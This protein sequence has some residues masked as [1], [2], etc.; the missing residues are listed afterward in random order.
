[1]C[2]KDMKSNT[3]TVEHRRNPNKKS[4][5]ASDANH[6]IA[7]SMV[8]VAIQNTNW[9]GKTPSV[10]S[11]YMVR[12]RYRQPFVRASILDISNASQT[13]TLVL[14]ENTDPITPG[15]SLVIYSEHANKFQVRECLG[16]GIICD[17]I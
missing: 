10:G 5:T 6:S 15:Q 17:I 16:G 13:A 12:T 4:L 1:V 3:I 7:N 2:A 8:E 11:S 9:V 14:N